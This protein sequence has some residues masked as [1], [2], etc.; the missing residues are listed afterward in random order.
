M[1]IELTRFRVKAGKESR[2]DDWMQ[3]LND[4]PEAMR[5]TLEPEQMYVESIFS[6][7][8]DGEQYLYWYSVQGED[9]R[10]D[11]SQSHH[12]LDE[13][14][15]A[16]WRECIDDSYE[17]QDLASRVFALPE[18]VHSAMTPLSTQDQEN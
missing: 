12:W 1:K 15:V 5:E 18:R 7:V 17:A 16:F 11:V 3:L 4:H 9:G 2:V 8:V 10:V 6:E 13:K 14:H